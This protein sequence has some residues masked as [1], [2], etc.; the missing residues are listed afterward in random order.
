MVLSL[1]VFAWIWGDGSPSDL[2]LKTNSDPSAQGCIQSVQTPK[3]AASMLGCQLELRPS[4]T[5]LLRNSETCTG[6]ETQ[7]ISCLL[8]SVLT[9]VR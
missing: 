3:A 8:V 1:Q 6:L 7:P 5:L 9:R 2:S 4:I